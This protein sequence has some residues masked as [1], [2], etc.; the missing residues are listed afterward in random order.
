MLHL[1]YV[2]AFS[3]LA[4]IA[5]ANLIRNLIVLGSQS[6]RNYPPKVEDLPSVS[7]NRLSQ[8]SVPH[9]EFLDDTGN[10][11]REPLLVM[12]SISVE[13]AREKLDALYNSSPEPEEK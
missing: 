7:Q 10:P 5:V 9:P 2:F 3:T 4:F 6:T 13:D 1:I 11:I 8:M 12:R